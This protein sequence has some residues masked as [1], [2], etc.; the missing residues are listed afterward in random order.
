[1]QILDILSK[2]VNKN[3]N[4]HFIIIKLLLINKYVFFCYTEYLLKLL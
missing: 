3:N 4:I 2:Y 1:M